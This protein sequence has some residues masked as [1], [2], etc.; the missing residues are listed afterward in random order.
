MFSNV[1]GQVEYERLQKR[2]PGC[3]TRMEEL[4][5]GLV[6]TRPRAVAT[7][8]V[9]I[10]ANSP[11]PSQ[12]EDVRMQTLQQMSQLL[13]EAKATKTNLEF[14]ETAEKPSENQTSEPAKRTRRPGQR[15]APGG[16]SEQSDQNPD[17]AENMSGPKVMKSEHGGQVVVGNIMQRTLEANPKMATNSTFLKHQLTG[18][19]QMKPY[20][21]L[22]PENKK[23]KL[24]NKLML[25]SAA[26][27]SHNTTRANFVKR[28]SQGQESHMQLQS[29]DYV[30]F[31]TREVAGRVSNL[32]LWSQN[33]QVEALM[34]NTARNTQGN[35]NTFGAKGRSFQNE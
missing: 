11:Q 18:G 6:R 29:S 19:R 31:N 15:L 1:H 24:L 35:L 13:P 20:E 7:T 23:F 3:L 27:R 5:D 4:R 8:A 22:K 32:Q 12:L 34:N 21:H 16:E 14:N 28:R 33:M 2:H 9:M 30:G 17:L 25:P 26:H 10:E